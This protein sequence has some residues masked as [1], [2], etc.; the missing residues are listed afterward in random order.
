MPF[1]EEFLLLSHSIFKT[2][3]KQHLFR[4]YTLL[5]INQQ[6]NHEVQ[7]IPNSYFIVLFFNLNYL[8]Q[9][10]YKIITI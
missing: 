5:N 8:H 6:A 1:D 2:D 3:V 4:G 10:L 9:L 7:V